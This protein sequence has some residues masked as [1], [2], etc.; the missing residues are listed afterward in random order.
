MAIRQQDIIKISDA[1]R[2][3]IKQNT[4]VINTGSKK[5]RQ[6]I[7]VLKVMSVFA[8]EKTVEKGFAQLSA[9][10]KN[11]KEWL[12]MSTAFN[13]LLKEGVFDVN[14]KQNNS[15]GFHK[16]RFDSFPVH[17]RML[18]D[19]TRTLAFQNA[20]RELVTSDDIVL[21]IGTGNGILAATAAMCGAKH[22]YAVEQTDFIEVARAVFKANGLDDKITL[23]RGNSKDIE[24]P[25]KATVLVSEIIG[26][27]P[28]DEGIL[29]TFKDAKQRLLTADARLIPSQIHV[30]AALWEM[31][32]GLY[33]KNIPAQ[34]NIEQWKEWYGIDFSAFGQFIEQGDNGNIPLK[35]PISENWK[36]LAPDCL[37]TSVDFYKDITT[38]QVSV[39]ASTSETGIFNALQVSF[40]AV[41]SPKQ[42][43]STRYSVKQT[44]NHW[45]SVVKQLLHPVQVT[46]EKKI[47]FD[48]TLKNLK[49]FIELK[50]ETV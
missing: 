21:D 5:L 26:N 12:A 46:K 47:T 14:N 18:N 22:V 49:S 39:V 35:T 43:I 29:A 16:A 24:L 50:K 17:I 11:K 41:L 48:Y 9:E 44:D 25:Q 6:P 32:D 37:I 13:T 34:K 20:I 45:A 15:I 30:Y 7:E 31:P 23:I 38:P 8:T 3:N 27:D 4:V 33:S 1:L 42:M 2:F 10:A 40:E 28:F 36:Q 19:K